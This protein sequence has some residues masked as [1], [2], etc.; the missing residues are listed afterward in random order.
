MIT[1]FYLYNYGSVIIAAIIHCI[2]LFELTTGVSKPP[3]CVM[4]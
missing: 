3:V 2:Y 4:P 1:I